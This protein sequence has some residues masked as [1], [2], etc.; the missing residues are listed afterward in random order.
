MEKLYGI[1]K[2]QIIGQSI[3]NFMPRIFAK[4]HSIYMTHYL[5]TGKEEVLNKKR[6][7]FAID[8][9]GYVFPTAIYVKFNPNVQKGISYISLLRPLPVD[10]KQNNT[11]IDFHYYMLCYSDGRI[12]SVSRNLSEELYLN[13]KLLK[14]EI[15]YL[16]TLSTEFRIIT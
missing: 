7:V 13:S 11:Q 10:C 6:V 3:D 12:D 2:S 8:H 1:P 16:W 14:N 5:K 15:V 4:D 9:D